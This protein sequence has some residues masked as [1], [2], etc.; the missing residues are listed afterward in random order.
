MTTS[1]VS[2]E[3]QTLSDSIKATF[4]LISRLSKLS[5]QP[6]SE[7]LEGEVSV[8]IELAQDIHD[9]LKQHEE[10]L[11]LLRQEV[12]DQSG[13]SNYGHRRRDTEKDR[14]T[15]RLAA[16]IVR[17]GEDLKHARNQ[18]RKA[19][20][21]AKRAA[22]AAKR[23]ERELIFASIQAGSDPSS[24]ASTPDLFAHRKKPQLKQLS[25]DEAIVGASTDVTAALR[26]TH[27]LLSTELSRSRFAQE[28]FDQS[29]A[30]L[31]DLGEK[32]TDLNTILSKSRDLL[33]T[34]LKSQK[35]DTWY[36]E[37]AFWILLTTICWLFFRRI[38]YGPFIRLPIF[39]YSLTSFLVRWFLL[40]PTLY[41]LSAIGVITLG[42]LA[43]STS[44]AVTSSSRPPLIVH[45]S[46]SQRAPTF[47][48]TDGRPPPG[49][50]AG[51]GGAGAKV[52]KDGKRPH[53][54][55][56]SADG[57]LSQKIG[58]MAEESQQQAKGEKELP[59]RGDGTILQERGDIPRNPK[60]KVFEDV[61]PASS[62]SRKRDEL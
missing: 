59:R 23:K 25:K 1:K 27:D 41:F 3:V 58:Q 61:E 55:D 48:M 38:L 52:D 43:A 6:G 4:N 22:E 34:L 44:I 56:P 31:A 62:D 51:A 17:L 9:S 10:E 16:Q 32:Y 28:T 50:R 14:E 18:F 30:A 11:E 60:K 5:F 39:F 19:Q 21:T 54:K 45:P 53:E 12:E 42:P 20:L 33:G 7:P 49:V 37:T 57:S 40:K 46:A 13:S 15:A 8:R 24:N 47:S 2:H 35:S 26:R 36:L 29:T